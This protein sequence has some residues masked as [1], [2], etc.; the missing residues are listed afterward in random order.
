MK[1]AGV[2]VQFVG[3]GDAFGSGGRLQACISVRS[4]EERVL[5][6]CGASS[7]VGLQRLGID[8]NEISTIFVSHFHGDHFGGIP[9]LFLYYQG[10][11]KRQEPLTIVGPTNLEDRVWKLSEG[12][13]E[14]TADNDWSFDIQFVEMD[15]EDTREVGGIKVQSYPAIHPPNSNPRIYRIEI[16]GR[17]IAYSGDTNWTGALVSASQ[18]ADLLICECN[19]FDTTGE[20]HIDYM[21]FRKRRDLLS[22]KQLVLTHMGAEMIARLDEVED[23][24]AEDGKI[25]RL[26]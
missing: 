18:D 14:G 13:Y 20:F 12:L 19:Y 24:V 11:T 6:D 17:T 4:G 9:Y 15:E 21:N 23:P 7:L 8:P 25:I 3:S 2:E 22:C 16:G 1:Q 10:V 5:L 26:T